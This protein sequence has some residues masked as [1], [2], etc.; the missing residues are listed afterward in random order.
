MPN[1][2]ATTCKLDEMFGQMAD[3]PSQQA[4]QIYGV[5]VKKQAQQIYGVALKN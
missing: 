5:A 4:Q 3:P 1:A 2:Q